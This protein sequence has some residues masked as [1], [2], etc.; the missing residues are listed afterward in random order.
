MKQ[1]RIIPQYLQLAIRNDEALN[2][3]LDAAKNEDTIDE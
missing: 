2:K 3:L 1:N